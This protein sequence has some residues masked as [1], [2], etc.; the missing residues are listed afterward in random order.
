MKVLIACEFSGTVRDAFILRGHDA[1]SCDI[2]PSERPGP[3][4]QEDVLLHLDEG[5][6]IMI[7]FPP[8]TDLAIA[9]ARYWAEKEKDGRVQKA[10]NFVLDLYNAPIDKIA[11]ENPVGLLNTRFRKPDQIINPYQFGEPW[12]KRTCLWLKGLPKLQPTQTVEPKG[13]WVSAR[14]GG[15]HRSPR[16]RSLTFPGIAKAMSEQW[17]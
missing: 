11:I 3:H 12:K 1:I 4:I 16:I 6:D 10:M 14:C 9:G 13:H 2:I 8:C 7:A 17:G 5:W 15:A